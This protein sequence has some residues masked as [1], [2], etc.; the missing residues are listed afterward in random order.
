M[1]QSTIKVILG[2]LILLGL[3]SSMTSCGHHEVKLSNGAVIDAYDEHDRTYKKGDTVC[4]RRVAGQDRVQID[5][6]GKMLDTTFVTVLGNL[7]EY[8]KAIIQ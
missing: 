1:K 6:T 7:V 4:V 5:E 8:R 3:L 2:I